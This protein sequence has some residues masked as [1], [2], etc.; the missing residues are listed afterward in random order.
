MVNNYTQVD[1]LNTQS[2]PITMSLT[3]LH[4]HQPKPLIHAG[5]IHAFMFM[6]NSNLT[7]YVAAESNLRPDSGQFWKQK[8]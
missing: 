6:P 3:P 8:I 7:E 2:V 1:I 4:H 5:W